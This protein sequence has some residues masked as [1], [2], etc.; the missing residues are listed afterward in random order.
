MSSPVIKILEQVQRIDLEI[1]SMEEEEKGYQARIEALGSELGEVT[2]EIGRFDAEVEELRGL[3][4]GVEERV[5]ESTEKVKKDEVRLGAIKNDREM[6]ALSKGINTTNKA[7]RQAERE[8]EELNSKLTDKKVTREARLLDADKKRSE[9]ETLTGELKAKRASWQDDVRERAKERDELKASLSPEVVSRYETIKGKRG[10]RAV[11]LVRDEAC[12][13]CYMKIPPQ[14]YIQ[15]KRG[16]SGLMSCP[17]CHRILYVE[18]Q[19]QPEAI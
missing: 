17:H 15:L 10:G 13:G 6:K 12:Q 8:L 5:R 4:R 14:V 7:K 9:M 3:V 2:E 16:E 11:V 18:E 1:S 19:V